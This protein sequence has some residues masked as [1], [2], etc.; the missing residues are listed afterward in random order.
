MLKKKLRRGWTTGACAT[1]A[2]KAAYIGL[3]TGICPD[4][5]TITLPNGQTPTFTIAYQDV[6]HQSVSAGI[7]KD[8]GDDPDVT[9]GILII[10]KVETCHENNGVKF[11]AGNGVGTVTLPGLPLDVGEPA[12]NPGPRKMIID[13]LQEVAIQNS[14]K[15]EVNITI[16]VPE[17]YEIAKKTWNTRLGIQNGISILG[18]TGI[19]IPF[20]CAAWIHSIH[21]GVDVAKKTNLLHIAA[22][23]GSISEKVT[24]N[25]FELPDQAMIDMG[26][27]VGGLLKY[28]KKNTV[29][30]IT[31][32]GGFAKLVK[33]SQGSMDLHSSRSQV[34]LLSLI[35]NIKELKIDGEIFK[36][37]ERITTANQCL[38]I[39]GDIKYDLSLNIAK[40]AQDQILNMLKQTQIGI[41]VMIIDRK[42]EILAQTDIRYA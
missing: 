38:E 12:I 24:Q 40:M 3:L 39:L 4:K 37:I 34:D 13:T 31:I 29:P 35:E 19:V 20:S 30:R 26:D 36:D 6:N 41:D 2:S 16:E 22:C 21:R 7:I 14:V 1:A 23:T 32:A 5:I 33:L 8:A 42:E 15:L 18:T 25:Y 17:G 27:F 11:F 10:S 9:N 28:L